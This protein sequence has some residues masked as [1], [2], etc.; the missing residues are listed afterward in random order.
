MGGEWRG[1]GGHGIGVGGGGGSHVVINQAGFGRAH[2]LGK[3]FE[4]CLADA[5]QAPEMLQQG[6]AGGLPTPLM[7]SSVERVCPRLRRDR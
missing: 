6:G 2:H 7:L 3:L 4:R 5:L 1:G